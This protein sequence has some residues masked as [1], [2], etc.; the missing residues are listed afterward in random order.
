MKNKRKYLILDIIV[1]ICELLFIFLGI[2][3][4]II[5]YKLLTIDGELMRDLPLII[6]EGVLLLITVVA[7]IIAN[8][9]LSKKEKGDKENEQGV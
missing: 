4:L 3:A 7:Y 8:R 5:G 6:T 1:L 2:M 9:L